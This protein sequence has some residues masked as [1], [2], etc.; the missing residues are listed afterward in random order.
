[1]AELW[2]R[3]EVWPLLEALLDRDQLADTRA[4]FGDAD[5]QRGQMPS[6]DWYDDISR[7]RG[8]SWKWVTVSAV[9][10][11]C[12]PR[13][14]VKY[15][16]QLQLSVRAI[17]KP[18]LDA[19]LADCPAELRPRFDGQDNVWRWPDNGSNLTAAGAN[20]GHYAALRGQ[21]AHL[22]VQD[23][24]GFYDDFDAVQR[25]LRPQLQTIQGASVYATTPPESPDHPIEDVCQALKAQ[26]RYVHR[27]IHGPGGHP[28]LTPEEIEG[29]LMREAKLKGLSLEAFRRTTYYRREFLCMHVAEET[30]AVVPEWMEPVHEVG[31]DEGCTLGDALTHDYARP[32]LYDAYDSFDF[33]YTRDPH[34]GLF[35]FWDST[36]GRLVIEDELP[37]LYRTR[38]DGLAEAIVAKRR[39][40]W[41][42]RDLD[43][44]KAI[45]PPTQD[46]R[47]SEC[48][49]YW[50]PYR[51]IGDGGGRGMETI[52]ELAKEHQVYLSPTS[53]EDLE[54]MVNDLRRL[55]AAQKLIIHPRCVHLRKQLAR[56]L[57]ADKVKS[58]FARQTD[59]H[60]DHLAAL[61][62]LVRNVDRQ[63]NPIPSGWGIDVTQHIVVGRSRTTTG[64]AALEAVLGGTE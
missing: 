46:A 19:V 54:V 58:D 33:G 57:W 56:A 60:C 27:T 4:F 24:A 17:I 44:R 43:G 6:E 49:T 21:R 42:A 48:G 39:A 11:H 50:L 61:I 34:A 13:F 53:K 36:W 26:G 40:L 1:M 5:I 12:V 30:R 9:L 38:S 23:E 37:P 15:A 59:G 51:S 55:A 28:R 35:G 32:V 16:A 8:K 14:I 62:Y 52:G 63:R 7:Q 25:A 64:V 31:S 29:V 20:L 41:P 2:R 10:C 45:P 47:V 22:L 18:T 3:R